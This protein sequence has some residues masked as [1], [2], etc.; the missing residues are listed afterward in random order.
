MLGKGFE[1]C[2]CLHLYL[3]GEVHVDVKR[4]VGLVAVLVERE[5]NA[6]TQGLGENRSAVVKDT[7]VEAQG[8]R[9]QMCRATRHAPVL[10]LAVQGS[11]VRV[12]AHR[13]VDA[14]G[15][16]LGFA[17]MLVHRHGHRFAPC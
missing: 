11:G 17:S 4:L 14:A 15:S 5:A 9:P 16:D 12:Q 3:Q 8:P 10:A 6:A 13:G 7:D 1:N 2:S